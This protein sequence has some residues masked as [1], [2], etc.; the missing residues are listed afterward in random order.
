MF[1]PQRLTCLHFST[2]LLEKLP[3]R[4]DAVNAFL[5]YSRGQLAVAPCTDC[6]D[7]YELYGSARP[8]PDC[9]FL[10]NYWGF[11]CASCIARHRAVECSF[12]ILRAEYR[13]L[14]WE[15]AQI[16]TDEVGAPGSKWLERGH[17]LSTFESQSLNTIWK[18]CRHAGSGLAHD[19][20]QPLQEPSFVYPPD[21]PNAKLPD[22]S[23]QASISSNH[24]D[25][26]SA[27]KEK[28]SSKRNIIVITGAGVSTNAGSKSRSKFTLV[29][30]LT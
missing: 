25:P 2:N 29:T 24:A 21:V 8:F 11:A 26:L 28:L 7:S 9:V 18:R 22:N 27:L 14:R 19:L 23:W 13:D 3:K 10:P 12:N 6:A 1:P 15:N 16:R 17:P 4:P 30:L 20:T 5:A